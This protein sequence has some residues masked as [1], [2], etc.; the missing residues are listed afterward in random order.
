MY[1]ALGAN[2]G[3]DIAEGVGHTTGWATPKTIYQH[4]WPNI[5]GSGYSSSSDVQTGSFTD[6]T[7]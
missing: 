7:Y 1:E 5:T 4:V 2:P 6:L 3:I